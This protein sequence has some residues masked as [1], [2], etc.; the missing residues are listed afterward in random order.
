VT[1]SND[2]VV[3]SVSD[4]CGET[5]S[6]TVTFTATDACE[7]SSSTSATFTIVDT[8]DPVITCP[9][10]VTVE[11]DESFDPSALGFASADDVCDLNVTVSYSDSSF[12]EFCDPNIEI[13]TR[14]WTATEG[15]GKSV[16]CDQI[17]KVVDVTAPTI[18]CP[19][20]VTVECGASTDV[21]DLGIASADDNC[22]TDV[23]VSFTDSSA[24]G[25]C[26]IYVEFITRTWSAIDNCYNTASCDQVI[27]VEDTTP[28]VIS[29]PSDVTVGCDE[30]T[31]VSELGSATAE[32][33]CDPDVHVS[34]TDSI[35]GILCDSDAV[36][37]RTWTARDRCGNTDVCDQVITAEDT[38]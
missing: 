9:S 24:D 14:T 13:I 22:D 12:N 19:S 35:A 34:F 2:Y 28:P 5:G 18:S 16:S 36:I 1:W 10:D 23:V 33:I 4:L 3:D 15:C 29:C 17:I 25:F 32:D 37:T 7:N 30:S 11:C 38:T 8:L 21:S 6:V 26:D 27:T 20:D 31:G